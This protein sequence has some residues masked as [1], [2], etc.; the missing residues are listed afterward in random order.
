MFFYQAL[1]SIRTGVLI[2]TLTTLIMLP[3][4]L[5][6]GIAAGYFLGW[7]DDV[8]Q[9]IYMTLNSIPSVLLIAAAVLMLH[10][11]MNQN[12]EAFD[13]LAVRADMRLLFLC[14]ILGITSWTGLCRLLRAETLKLKN[15]DYIQAAN[16]LGVSQSGIITRHIL[17]N[18]HAYCFYYCG[19]G[20]Q[21]FGI[22]GSGVVLCQ[23]RS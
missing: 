8:I 3:F 17:P 7:A 4:A 21:R 13:N 11:Y 5:L 12:Q 10:L 16:V 19:I 6:L 18:V 20:F 22:G 1:K 23:Y 2:G 9:Y 15:M 14:A